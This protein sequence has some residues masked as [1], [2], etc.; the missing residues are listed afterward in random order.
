MG[1]KTLLTVEQFERLPEIEG[2]SYEL[3]QGELV[4]V[5]SQAYLHNR[6][7]G[8]IEWTVRNHLAVHTEQGEVVAEQPFRLGDDTVRIPDVALIVP[9]Q[10]GMIETSGSVLPFCPK[11]VIEVTSPSNTVGDLARRIRQYL[12]AGA[13]TIWVFVP[14]LREVHV[15]SASAKPKILSAD[16]MLDEP[17][18]LPGF[19]IRVGKLFEV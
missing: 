1:A 19:S 12:D 13:Q 14:P 18:L 16:D 7:R 2:I 9:Q 4:E 5:S 17:A 15:Y 3:D 6:I 8:L 10:L 11:L